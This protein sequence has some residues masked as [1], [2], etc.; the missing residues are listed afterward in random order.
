MAHQVIK[1]WRERRARGANRLF[2]GVVKYVADQVAV[3]GQAHHRNGARAER[4]LQWPQHNYVRTSAAAAL[5][6]MQQTW[7]RG[8]CIDPT[9]G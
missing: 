2:I 5:R 8:C 4:V 9:G 3:S 7:Q 1:V 6:P